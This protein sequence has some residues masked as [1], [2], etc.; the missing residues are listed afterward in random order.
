MMDFW[1][2]VAK[3]FSDNPNVIGYDILN[4]PWAANMYHDASLFYDTKKFDRTK[5]FPLS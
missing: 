1:K 2:V 5:L 4:E 3:K